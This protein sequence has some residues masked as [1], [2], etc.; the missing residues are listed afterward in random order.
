MNAPSKDI[1]DMLV[2][3]SSLGLVL[4]TNLFIGREQADKKVCTTVFDTPGYRPDLSIDRERYERPSVLIRVKHT[5]YL[6]GMDLLQLIMESL[7]G[8]ANETWGG[9]LYTVIVA[10]DQPHLFDYDDNHNP[11]FILNINIQRRM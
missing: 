5:D 3:D 10:A 6:S 8:R 4:G 2:A 11:R 9:A 7:H 1:A